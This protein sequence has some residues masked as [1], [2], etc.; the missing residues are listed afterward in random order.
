MWRGRGDGDWPFEWPYGRQ[1]AGE[2]TSWTRRL[3]PLVIAV[4]L[5]ALVICAA[6]PLGQ[7]A[8]AWAMEKPFAAHTPGATTPT[9]TRDP[10]AEVTPTPVSP[11]QA[12]VE[13][14]MAQMSLDEKLGQMV[15]VETYSQSYSGDIK[16]MVEQQHAGALIIYA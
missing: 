5:I 14:Y 4:S 10:A 11:I 2:H 16:T 12:T 13:A 15:M 7:R 9:P 6:G 8:R 3:L 1:R